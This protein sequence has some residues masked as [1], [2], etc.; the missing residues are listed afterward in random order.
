MSWNNQ[1]YTLQATKDGVTKY[2][3]AYWISE[4]VITLKNDIT[5][6]WEYENP[7]AQI[8]KCSFVSE[9]QAWFIWYQWKNQ[10]LEEADGWRPEVCILET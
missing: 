1:I 4:N 2:C 5:L 3:T 10:H 9:N 8:N 7:N 6:A